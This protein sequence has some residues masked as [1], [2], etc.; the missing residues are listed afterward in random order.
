MENNHQILFGDIHNHNAMG[1]G[2]GSL[3][4]TIDIAR[5]HLDFFS[6][7]G[8]AYWHDMVPMEGGRENHW[9][10]GFKRLEEGWPK[11]QN[12]ISDA[13][14]AENFSA[15][16]GYEWHSSAFGDQ[17][18]VFPE[19]HR[20]LYKPDTVSELRKFCMEEQ[21]LMIPHHLAYP[22]G[23]RG[24][25]WDVF[26]QCCTPV[27]EIFSEHGNSEDDRIH[28][29]PPNLQVPSHNHP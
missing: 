24:V 10:E 25:N 22:K 26:D 29:T 3:E 27:V 1:Y 19:D 21:A 16:L 5:Q 14:G 11:I 13:N 15:F 23:H 12:L 8:H 28:P 18:V 6:F 7:T 9:I 2:V 17:C 20:P 4:R